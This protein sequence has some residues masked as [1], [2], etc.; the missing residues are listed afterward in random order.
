M[1]T[2]PWPGAS[3]Q[4]IGDVKTE[5]G[6]Y[7]KVHFWGEISATHVGL[8]GFRL[9]AERLP[10]RLYIIVVPVWS[11]TMTI[12]YQQHYDCGARGSAMDCRDPT[13]I[14]ILFTIVK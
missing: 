8:A 9:L 2:Y 5:V 12:R 13:R 10:R 11:S 6:T 7:V 14:N 3:R 1:C 4:G